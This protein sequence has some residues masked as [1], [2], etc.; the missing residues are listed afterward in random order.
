MSGR[1]SKY[2]LSLW[3]E[4]C[5][6]LVSPLCPEIT[7]RRLNILHYHFYP[8]V[9]FPFNI[10]TS[11]ETEL[12]HSNGIKSHNYPRT[13]WSDLESLQ[14]RGVGLKSGRGSQGLSN[15]FRNNSRWLKT[16]VL[17]RQSYLYVTVEELL[18]I[19][20]NW[21][22]IEANL[23]QRFPSHPHESRNTSQAS[24]WLKWHVMT[25][26]KNFSCFDFFHRI[27]CVT[28]REEND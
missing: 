18:F 2:N 20:K 11:S 9:H 24:L 10:S 26:G 19:W 15:H 1:A 14:E 23:V 16:A 17:N 8:L 28:D 13:S 5:S 4:T 22:P 21:P 6:G 7:F 12:V 3:V 27:C 25:V